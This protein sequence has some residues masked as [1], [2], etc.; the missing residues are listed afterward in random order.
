MMALMTEK[1]ETLENA[2]LVA[3]VERLSTALTE[4]LKCIKELERGRN[5]PPGFVKPNRPKRE[6][7]KRPCKKRAAE[8]DT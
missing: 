5:Q 8:H 6:S 7:Q 4:A 1:R 3:E 2:R